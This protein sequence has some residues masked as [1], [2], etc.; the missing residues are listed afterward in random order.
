MLNRS[1]VYVLW[2]VEEYYTKC[3]K[4]GRDRK[5]FEFSNPEFGAFSEPL[6]VVDLKCRIILWYLPRLLPFTH[7]PCDSQHWALAEKVSEE[8]HTE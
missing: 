7:L 8:R 1:I 6:T 3:V 2:D 5:H 4:A